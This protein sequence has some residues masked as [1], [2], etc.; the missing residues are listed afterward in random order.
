LGEWN[1]SRNGAFS[2]RKLDELQR[3]YI[4]LLVV[5]RQSWN[6]KNNSQDEFDQIAQSIA[7]EQLIE[8]EEMTA[9]FPTFDNLLQ[10]A[11]RLLSS[12][13]SHLWQGF[14]DACEADAER[15]QRE[16]EAKGNN[17]FYPGLY[18]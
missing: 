8:D 4:R 15:Y 13:V 5:K 11:K 14:M 7:F 18:W 12:D 16:L 1:Q 2:P 17:D 3:L 10:R 6:T 9:L